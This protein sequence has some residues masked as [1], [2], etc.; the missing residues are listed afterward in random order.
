MAIA[1]TPTLLSLDRWAK[2]VGLTPVHFNGATAG[3]LWPQRQHCSDIWAQYA[4]QTPAQLV[5]REEIAYEIA[6]A[7]AD[8]KAMLGYSPAPDWEW[9]ENH[10]WP[11]GAYRYQSIG[12]ALNWGKLIGPGFRGATVIKEGAEVT[13]SDADGD[14]WSELATVI[15]NTAVTDKREVKLFFADHEGDA[16][17][18]IRPLRKVVL[19]ADAGTATITA[20][21]WLF[22]AP[23]LWEEYPRDDDDEMQAIPIANTENYVDVVDAYRIFNDYATAP[24]SILVSQRNHNVFCNY[25]TVGLCPSCGATIQE[26]AF[27][28]MSGENAFVAPFPASYADG[29]WTAQPWA[30]CGY[31]RLMALSYYAGAVDK[32]YASGKTLDPLSD[33]WADSIAWMAVARLPRGVCGCDN[34]R[35]RIE[36]MQRDLTRNDQVSG[37]VRTPKMDIFSSAFGTRVGEVRAWQACTRIAQDVVASGAIL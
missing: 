35:Q 2:I 25:C 23:E 14:G 26:G 29:V 32:R 22:I 34:I 4:W 7:E 3:H 12:V 27:D 6:K 16:E 19:D 13:F 36:E 10:T 30:N 18:E 20:D 37:F 31:P 11:G 5:S 15:V 33:F 28:A 9:R 1:S 17:F 24:A 8:I 21:A